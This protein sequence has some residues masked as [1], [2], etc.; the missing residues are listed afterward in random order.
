MTGPHW[1]PRSGRTRGTG[2]VVPYPPLINHGGFF[3]F[4]FSHSHNCARFGAG[5]GSGGAFAYAYLRD[6]RGRAAQYLDRVGAGG[7][8]KYT[9]AGVDYANVGSGVG[10]LA[11][12]PR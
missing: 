1:L 9:P 10:L 6:G 3:G 5:N 7:S 12:V 11:D 4:R 2:A 8:G